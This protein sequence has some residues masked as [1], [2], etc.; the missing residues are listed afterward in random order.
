[1]PWVESTCVKHVTRHVDVTSRTYATRRLATPWP[2]IRKRSPMFA[3][4]AQNVTGISEAARVTPTTS[5]AHQR[6]NHYVTESRIMRRV[7]GS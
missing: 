2:S 1:M 5:R 4:H 6:K 7:D 3:T